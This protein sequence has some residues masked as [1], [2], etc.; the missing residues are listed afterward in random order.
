M[1]M[2]ESLWSPCMDVYLNAYLYIKN[3]SMIRIWMRL[4]LSLCFS[5]SVS[6]NDLQQRY[7][8]T[9]RSMF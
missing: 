8:F 7:R 5:V 6:F 3:K 1:H 9:V 2:Y 4:S